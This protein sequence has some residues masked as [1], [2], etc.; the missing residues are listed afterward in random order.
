MT[1]FFLR[2]LSIGKKQSVDACLTFYTFFF[3]PNQIITQKPFIHSF[4]LKTLRKNRFF[5]CYSNFFVSFYRFIACHYYY[6]W[7]VFQYV[8]QHGIWEV[9]FSFIITY[10]SSNNRA[11]H[12]YTEF[13]HHHRWGYV[14]RYKAAKHIHRKKTQTNF[15]FL[16]IIILT[17][18]A[19]FLCGY[20]KQIIL[21]C[22]MLCFAKVVRFHKPSSIHFALCDL[23]LK[24]E[25]P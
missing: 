4:K 13:I 12:I 16:E 11:P 25:S 15:F 8:V 23:A 3:C 20:A 22:R 21:T 5:L 14:I 6:T 17:K 7:N 19:L 24:D 10:C 9:V 18:N 2:K 1:F